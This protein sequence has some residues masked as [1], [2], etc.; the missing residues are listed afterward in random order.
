MAGESERALEGASGG[1][2]GE[3]ETTAIP[4]MENLLETKLDLI[5]K[6]AKE[7]PNVRFTTLAHLLNEEYLAECYGELKRRKASGIDGVSVEEYGEGLEEKLKGLVNRMKAKQYRPQAV[8]RVYI[9][10][11]NGTLRPLGIPAV[12]DKVVQMGLARILEA[13]FEGDFLDVSHG[14]RAGRGCHDALRAYDRMVMTKPVSYVIEVDIKGYYDHIDHGWLMKCLEQ[15]I[16]DPSFL[17]LIGRTLKAGVMEEGVRSETE[18]GAPQGGIVSPILSNIYLHYILDLWFERKLKKSLKGFAELIRYCDDFVIGCQYEWEAEEILAEL[19]ERLKKF[20]LEVSEEKTRIV[21][22][23]RFARERAEKRGVKAGTVEFLG[24]THFCA[25]SRSGRFIVGRRTSGK[26]FRAKL[27]AMN[28]WLKGV[29][30]MIALADWWRVLRWKLN[31]H[32][33]YYGVTG[34]W[35]GISRFYQEVLRMTYKWWNR[36]S[37]KRSGDWEEFQRRLQWNPLPKPRIAHV[38]RLGSAL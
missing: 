4:E 25:T 2:K 21:E 1:T 17:S 36:R 18:M 32:Y 24:F 23:G 5:A 38:F 37:Q 33:Q 35:R 34:N 19:K 11:G 13:I 22:F 10:K 7:E 16:A 14:F 6:R 12:E 8:R 27:V 15:R 30:N 20:G 28:Q 31:G 29:R 3:G 26:R 9:P